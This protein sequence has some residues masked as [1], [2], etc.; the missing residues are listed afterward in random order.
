LVENKHRP[1]GP[2]D[3]V[4]NLKVKN[5]PVKRSALP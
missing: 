2:S 3:R 5:E 1:I 4:P